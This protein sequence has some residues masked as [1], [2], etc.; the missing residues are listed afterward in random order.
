MIEQTIIDY[1]GAVLHKFGDINES[2]PYSIHIT[3]DLSDFQTQTYGR[4]PEWGI[5]ITMKNPNRI[6]M[7]SF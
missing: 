7:Q 3:S 1:S 6:I 2:A 4:A 5:A